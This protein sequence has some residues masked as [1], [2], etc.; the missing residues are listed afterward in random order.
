MFTGTSTGS[1]IACGL[2]LGISTTT[3]KDL[4]LENGEK[5][6][7]KLNSPGNI[8]RSL[9]DRISR[10]D[11]SLPLY[12]P[13]P[14]EE[15]LQRSDIFPVTLLFE[16]LIKPTIITSYDT[17]NRKPVIFKSFQDRDRKIPVWEV[18]RASSAA[19]VAYPGHLLTNVSFLE[20]YQR[21]PGEINNNQGLDIQLDDN[22]IP[23]IDGGVVANNPA[24]CAISER[25][26]WDGDQW[27]STASR[28]AKL[29][30]IIVAS[31]GTGQTFRRIT[32]IE[33]QTWGGVDWTS[34]LEGIP[35]LDV[36]FD[37]TSGAIDY[38]SAQILGNNYYR[39]QPVFSQNIPAFEGDKD[40]LKALINFANKYLDNGGDRDLDEF[41]AVIQ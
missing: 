21:A 22:K 20:T 30:K 29:D 7:P 38:I 37:G 34:V 19:P 17:Y 9:L 4:Y 33:A 31:F 23:L 2:A 28:G 10:V 15:L 35:L 18:C 16:Q 41:V 39:F 5:I 6:F 24:L 14:L 26:K 12:D 36:F 3:I 32:N 1:I 13:K 25:L 40:H 27:L 8:V 11:P